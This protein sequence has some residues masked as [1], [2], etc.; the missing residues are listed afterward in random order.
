ML[1]QASKNLDNEIELI[2]Q[3]KAG[4]V[5]AL[6]ELMAH[7]QTRI[8]SFIL[9]KGIKCHHDIEDLVQDTFIQIYKSITSF[10]FRSK[11]SS[12]VLGIALNIVRNHLNRS[13]KYKYNFVDVA[14]TVL[15]DENVNSEPEQA[16]ITQ[17]TIKTVNAQI[18]S[19]PEHLSEC[20]QL[21]CVQGISYSLAANK[22]ALSVAN[23]K[24]RLFRARKELKHKICEPFLMTKQPSSYN[25][26]LSV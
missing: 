3:S 17:Q 13:A 16:L 4:N 6:N 15:E 10:E 1:N 23:L 19:L 24:T 11:F 21:T 20:L 14:D 5:S 2:E 22:L 8:Y 12:W 9:A 26:I 7:Y 25:S 18:Q